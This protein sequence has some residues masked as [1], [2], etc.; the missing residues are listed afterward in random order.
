MGRD[1]FW[2][3]LQIRTDDR[4]IGMGGDPQKLSPTLLSVQGD[5]EQVA[6]HPDSL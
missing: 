4:V 6:Q 2:N 1:P 3:G 5:L